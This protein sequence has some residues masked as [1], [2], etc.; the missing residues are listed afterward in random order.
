MFVHMVVHMSIHTSEHIFMLH[1][2][3][4]MSIHMSIRMSIHMSMHMLFY[5]HVCTHIYTHV[6]AHVCMHVYTHICT[7]T[8]TSRISPSSHSCRRRIQPSTPHLMPAWCVETCSQTRVQACHIDV[9][10]GMCADVCIDILVIATSCGIFGII[11]CPCAHIFTP[12]RACVHMACLLTTSVHT[13]PHTCSMH[14]HTHL[15]PACA[16]TCVWAFAWTFVWTCTKA[17]QFDVHICTHMSQHVS[18]YM[19]IRTHVRTDVSTYLLARSCIHVRA[20]RWRSTHWQ[21][22]L[23]P[24]I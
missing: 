17:S 10:A 1:M 14:A 16:W 11:A 19:S 9:R 3:I 12:G 7:R 2:S 20:R 23:G 24:S 15:V 6:F 18:M 22:M 8:A 4:R 21:D 13:F 5:T